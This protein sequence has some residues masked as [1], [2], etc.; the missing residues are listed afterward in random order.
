MT[1]DLHRLPV[2]CKHRDYVH[3]DASNY[4][5]PIGKS[6]VP[7]NSLDAIVRRV[8]KL[9]HNHSALGKRSTLDDTKRSWPALEKKEMCERK[10]KGFAV[11]DDFTRVKR[12]RD[13]LSDGR[14]GRDS[15]FGDIEEPSNGDITIKV[16]AMRRGTAIVEAQV[17][18]GKLHG[19]VVW[20]HRFRFYDVYH[21]PRINRR[22]HGGNVETMYELKCQNDDFPK[23]KRNR[24]KYLRVR[25]GDIGYIR[26][27][28]NFE[29]GLPHG[30][31]KRD[32]EYP[33]DA[34]FKPLTYMRGELMEA[35][36]FTCLMRQQRTN[37]VNGLLESFVQIVKSKQETCELSAKNGLLDGKYFTSGKRFTES[38]HGRPNLLLPKYGHTISHVDP[39]YL[40]GRTVRYE[41][42]NAYC[43]QQP[44]YNLQLDN[45]GM[46][47]G[48]QRLFY[49]SR[50]T[51]PSKQ[52]WH[53]GWLNILLSS[54]LTE[55][56][57]C[58]PRLTR[59]NHLSGCK[60]RA[61]ESFNLGNYKETSVEIKIKGDRT[62]YRSPYRS[63]KPV[64][65]ISCVRY[66]S[67][68]KEYNTTGY[69]QMIQTKLDLWCSQ[70]SHQ[71][72]PVLSALVLDFYD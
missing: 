44:V 69:A 46:F 15:Y 37:I 56:D 70:F 17:L 48:I 34:G 39:R 10:V 52:R 12:I 58:L 6:A 62:P 5:P 4:K 50:S 19:R 16:P 41:A 26:I 40:T 65:V 42:L 33:I 13:R 61:K 49:Y 29:Y 64:L 55:T 47:D 38:G 18:D 45:N 14:W 51:V 20:E 11:W 2:I 25:Y 21:D 68:G 8:T 66:F 53:L 1:L 59:I 43:Q 67:N 27:V 32:P 72:P 71:F 9:C 3:V 23:D 57:P 31:C 63:L 35:H 36:D 30:V 7:F 24:K 22:K 54:P 28:M 60:P